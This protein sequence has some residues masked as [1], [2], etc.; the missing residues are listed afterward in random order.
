MKDQPKEKPK[1][2]REVEHVVD[3]TATEKDNRQE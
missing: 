3:E 1:V 2:I